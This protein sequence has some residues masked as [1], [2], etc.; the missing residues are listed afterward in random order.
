MRSDASKMPSNSRQWMNPRLDMLFL[1]HDEIIQFAQELLSTFSTSLGEVSLVPATGGVFIVDII[2]TSAQADQEFVDRQRSTTQTARLW[3]R[4]AQGGFPGTL[5][6][7]YSVMF[8]AATRLM[9]IC[10]FRFNHASSLAEGLSFVLKST[11]RALSLTY[12][13]ILSAIGVCPSYAPIDLFS[14]RFPKP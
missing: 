14:T 13:P 1:T 10:S 3:D 7:D 9:P 11:R 6:R 4:K 5:S 2:Y 8:V 12:V